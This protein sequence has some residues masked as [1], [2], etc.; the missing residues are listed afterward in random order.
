MERKLQG[1]KGQGLYQAGVS[2]RDRV[3]RTRA[4]VHQLGERI[5][6]DNGPAYQALRERVSGVRSPSRALSR[7]RRTA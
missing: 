5:R 4:R 7:N 2:T 3:R 6:R 1:S